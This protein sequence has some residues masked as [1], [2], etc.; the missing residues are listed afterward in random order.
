MTLQRAKYIWRQVDAGDASWFHFTRK[1]QARMA[2]IM[3]FGRES[4]NEKVKFGAWIFK[5]G[6]ENDD[7]FKSYSWNPLEEKTTET[8]KKYLD[9][10]FERFI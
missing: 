1:E 6:V 7:G 8:V 10:A 5:D 4:G 3:Y 9:R 2:D